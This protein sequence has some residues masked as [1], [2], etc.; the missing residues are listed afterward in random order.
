MQQI[1]IKNARLVNEG[2]IFEADLL[3][4]E[5][6]ILKIGQGL[7]EPGS[8]VIDARGQFLLPGVIDEQVYFREPGLTKKGTIA[9]E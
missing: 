5:D 3:T 7:A 4:K 9:S 6:R 2:K 8:K 1:L